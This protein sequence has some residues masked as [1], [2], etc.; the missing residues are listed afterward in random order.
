MLE[1]SLFLLMVDIKTVP[2]AATVFQRSC[3]V[4]S[5]TEQR[6]VLMRNVNCL[7]GFHFSHLKSDTYKSVQLNLACPHKNCLC[8]M[9]RFIIM[10]LSTATYI[11]PHGGIS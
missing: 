9:F 3:S 5:D 6:S 10:Q 2:S 4:L 7:Q 8:F 11:F 1:K